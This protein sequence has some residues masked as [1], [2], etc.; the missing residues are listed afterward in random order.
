L[1]SRTER[2]RVNRKGVDALFTPAKRER[3]RRILVGL[4]AIL[5]A[6]ALWTTVV[7]SR[8][9]RLVGTFVTTAYYSI[10]M[11]SLGEILAI[12]GIGITLTYLPLGSRREWSR[13]Q[14]DRTHRIEMLDSLNLRYGLLAFAESC[15]AVMLYSGLCEEYESNPSMQLWVRSS[16]PFGQFLLTEGGVL[17]LSAV[18]G[19]VIVQFLPGRLLAE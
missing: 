6:I 3:D 5:T 18:L 2:G 10:V 9:P 17:A 12:V 15:I 1:R 7:D 13:N 8:D 14:V 19:L 11:A 4:A 16:I